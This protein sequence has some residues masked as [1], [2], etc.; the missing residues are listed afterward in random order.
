[1]QAIQ[2]RVPLFVTTCAEHQRRI[3]ATGSEAS[4]QSCTADI[5]S[6]AKTSRMVWT[7]QMRL[8]FMEAVSELGLN[9]AV[10]KAI[11]SRLECPWLPRACVASHLQ[12]HRITLKQMAGSDNLN[13]MMA[14]HVRLL[15]LS[16]AY[17]RLPCHV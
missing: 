11:L 8:D 15:S 14:A 1:M 3:S 16:D 7:S 12:K 6:A 2:T 13:S 5:S 10:P 9:D 4:E 17:L